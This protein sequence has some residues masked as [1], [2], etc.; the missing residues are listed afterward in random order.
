MALPSGVN[1]GVQSGPSTLDTWMAVGPPACHNRRSR[2][3][4]LS[5]LLRSPTPLA[6]HDV[7]ADVAW[8]RHLRR[9]VHIRQRA[10]GTRAHVDPT[11]PL[12]SPPYRRSGQQPWQRLASNRQYAAAPTRP[13][14]SP[15]ASRRRSLAPRAGGASPTARML[16]SRLPGQDQ[17]TG[18]AASRTTGA[19]PVQ[20]Q[21]HRR[22]RL[23]L[24]RCQLCACYGNGDPPFAGCSDSLRL[25]RADCEA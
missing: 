7:D 1:T 3:A 23:R 20:I 4:E 17:S 11:Q 18:F 9:R 22:T 21:E 10:S 12:T 2:D 25:V 15:S 5:D 16:D 13:D 19:L 8:P 14:T 24:E 6:G